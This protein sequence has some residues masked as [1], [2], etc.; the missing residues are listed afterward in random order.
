MLQNVGGNHVKL[1]E[2][3]ASSWEVLELPIGAQR[4]AREGKLSAL[5]S[6]YWLCK[7]LCTFVWGRIWQ[8]SEFISKSP[9]LQSSIFLWYCPYLDV[10]CGHFKDLCGFKRCRPWEWMLRAQVSLGQRWVPV[11]VGTGIACWCRSPGSSPSSSGLTEVLTLRISLQ[12]LQNM[13]FGNDL[14]HLTKLRWNKLNSCLLPVLKLLLQSEPGS[15]VHGTPQ[16]VIWRWVSAEPKFI[17]V[18]V[19]LDWRRTAVL[20]LGKGKEEKYISIQEI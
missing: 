8:V 3:H 6:D 11:P 4:G 7:T 17:R 16:A 5:G 1:L 9:C 12:S 15:R 14:K 13:S 10:H 2:S 19:H 20:L 18:L